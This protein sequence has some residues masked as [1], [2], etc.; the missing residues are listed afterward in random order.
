MH[1]LHGELQ[2]IG[3]RS[4]GKMNIYLP[5]FCPV[6]AAKLVGK[7]FRCCLVVIGG[8]CVVREVIADR[9]LRDLLFEQ[10]CFVQKKDDRGALKP[11]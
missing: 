2:E 1:T 5:V 11:R 4:V 10:V 3:V 6:E 8:S 7:I 9:F